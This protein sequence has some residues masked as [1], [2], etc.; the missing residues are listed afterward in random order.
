MVSR[1]DHL[2]LAVVDGITIIAAF[3]F[4]DGEAI[5]V[6]QVVVKLIARG[7]AFE[8]L[9]VGLGEADWDV[10]QRSGKSPLKCTQNEGENK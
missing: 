2:A 7:E 1:G 4:H 9:S 8:D 3:A 6:V 5:G 10:L